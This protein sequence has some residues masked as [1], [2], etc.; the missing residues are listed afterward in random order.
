[1]KILVADDSKTNLSLITSSLKDLGHEVVAVTSGQQ[2]IESYQIAPQP[3]LI[4]LDVV[5]EGMSGFECAKQIRKLSANDWRPIIFLSG[6][7]DDDSIVKGIDAGGDDYL[8][9][10]F[11]QITLAAKIK[12]MQRISNMRKKL[13]DT[14]QK[15]RNLSSTDTLTGACNRLQFNKIIKVKIAEADR[16]NNMLGLLFLDLDEFKS[17]NDTLG[18]YVGDLQLIE[19]TKRLQTCLRINDFLARLGGDEF[20]IILNDIENSEIVK[21]LSQRIL[22][23][24]SSPYTLE[25]KV[26]QTTASIGIAL[27]PQDGINPEIL[28]KNADLAM[29]HAK[30]TGRNNYKYFTETLLRTNKLELDKEQKKISNSNKSISQNKVTLLHCIV[31]KTKICIEL[32]FIKKS[33]PLVQLQFMPNSPSYTVGLMNLAGVNIPVIDLGSRLNLPRTQRYT[34]DTP[35][36]LCSDGIHHT[37]FIVDK[38]LGLN[39]INKDELQRQGYKSTSLF[40]AAAPLGNEISLL[41]NIEHLLVIDLNTETS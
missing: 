24:L 1:M 3:D 10:P 34:L 22:S 2:A 8:T 40:I 5:M 12:A 35:I 17:I 29:Y 4:I 16:R 27:Y 19:V 20:A 25:N 21:E 7:V 11:S 23:A 36:L 33:L 9:K 13:F 39:E 30:K 41:L 15:L 38:I 14:T 6:S 28:I 26:I 32:Q 37:G 18:H 31:N